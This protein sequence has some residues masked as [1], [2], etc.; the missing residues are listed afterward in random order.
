[1]VVVPV[2]AGAPN[3]RASRA[4]DLVA[5]T[6]S[7]LY[8]GGFVDPQGWDR[9]VPD[10]VWD[11]FAPA[12]RSRA[13]EDATSFTVAALPA[14]VRRMHVATSSLTVRVLMGPNGSAEAAVAGLTFEAEGALE[15]GE[16]VAVSSH[17]TLLL[18]PIEGRWRIIAYPDTG[19]RI[20]LPPPAPEV[21]GPSAALAPVAAGPGGTR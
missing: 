19:T 4:A 6:L 13:R 16:G 21:R 18:R 17:A 3:D 9:S 11:A 1:M 2:R 5:G 7:E 8:D 15:S 10:R 14:N 20:A 12:I